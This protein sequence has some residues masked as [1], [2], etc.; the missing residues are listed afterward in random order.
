[1]C[2]SRQT[3][4]TRRAEGTIHRYMCTRYGDVTA[5]PV[6]QLKQSCR[7]IT[8]RDVYPGR[9]TSLPRHWMWTLKV[10]CPYTSLLVWYAALIGTGHSS[11]KDT[12]QKAARPVLD[13]TV[14]CE[15]S[16]A[17]HGAY[18][19]AAQHTRSRITASLSSVSNTDDRRPTTED[20]NISLK[21]CVELSIS[22]GLLYT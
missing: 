18:A 1:M 9:M 7:I 22:R 2:F 3:S 20:R 11:S 19:T 14:P 10:R 5:W 21:R 6:G 17:A 12:V 16:S 8:P 4:Y 13:I 15:V